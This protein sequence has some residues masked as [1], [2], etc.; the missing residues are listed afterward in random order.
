[1]PKRTFPKG[2]WR[3]NPLFRSLCKA[4]LACKTEK[5]IADF[6]RDVATLSELKAL[7]ERLQVALLLSKGLPYRD[8]S[9]RTGAST[10]TVSRVAL[11][12]GNGEG[13]YQNVL[14]SLDHH[15]AASS[16]SSAHTEL[17]RASMRRGRRGSVT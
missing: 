6:L 5:E 15:H 16:P 7:S 9:D 12:L 14:S 1:M 10:T 4:M 3:S 8:V 2:T 13:G 11:F 17:R